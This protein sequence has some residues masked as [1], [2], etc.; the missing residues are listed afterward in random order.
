MIPLVSVVNRSPLVNDRELPHVVAAIQR[1]VSCHLAPVWN[2]QARLHAVKTG[3]PVPTGSW[4][5]VLQDEL[6]VP[7]A[8]GYHVDEVTPS[9]VVGI[10]ICLDDRVSW[11][12]CLSHETLELLVDP[13]ATL[14]YEDGGKFWALEVCDP[15]ETTPYKID[16]VEVSNFVL[17]SWFRW[18]ATGPYDH[19]GVLASPLSLEQ[20]GYAMYRDGS[21][22]WQQVNAE[23]VRA[24]KQ[25]PRPG[26]RRSLRC[27]R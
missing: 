5:I 27:A 8:L 19:L 18:G 22:G 10:K 1:Q 25:V 16:G 21:G 12:S 7:G 15:C 24:A 20:G 6:D 13:W 3:E 2:V 11:S 23:L 26:S 4:P 9:G 14:A 17:P